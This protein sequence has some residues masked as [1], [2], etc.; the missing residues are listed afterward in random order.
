MENDLL[1]TVVAGLAQ[2]KGDWKRISS[3]LS[4]LVSYSLIAALG[5]GK[6]DSDPSY[7][8]LKLIAAYLGKAA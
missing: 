6:Y 8:K 5:R 3:E 2:R 4:P 7:K 1:E